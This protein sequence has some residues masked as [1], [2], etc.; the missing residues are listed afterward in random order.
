MKR[1]DFIRNT[2]WFVVGAALVPGC[3]ADNLSEADSAETAEAESTARHSFPQGLASGDPRA[4]S[5]VLWT[6][7]VRGADADGNPAPVRVRI[8]VA[9]DAGCEHRVVDREITATQASDHTVR[10]LITGL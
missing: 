6:R 1:R 2:G 7:V 3:V 5:V 4:T 8:Q 10:V 9:T